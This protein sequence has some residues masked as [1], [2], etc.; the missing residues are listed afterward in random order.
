MRILGRVGGDEDRDGEAVHRVFSLR[1]DDPQ[2]NGDPGG[3]AEPG[4]NDP[5]AKGFRATFSGPIA[6]GVAASAPV[7]SEPWCESAAPRE[8]DDVT[9][10]L[11]AVTVAY[12]DALPDPCFVSDVRGH[13]VAW[14]AAA[15]RLLGWTSRQA[16]GHW[17][18]ALL[19]GV[20][21]GGAPVCAVH[22]DRPAR[23]SR[24][25][26]E[27]HGDMTVRLASGARCSVAVSALPVVFDGE[28]GLLH[29]LRPAGG[30]RDSLTGALTRPVMR[31]RAAD[32][33]AH[34]RRFGEPLAVAL[35]DVDHLKWIND[36]KSHA[37]GDAALIAIARSLQ[38]RRDDLV[39]RWGGDEFLALLPG[40]TRVHAAARLRRSVATLA[41]PGMPGT[42]SAGVTELAGDERL[43]DAL[44]RCDAALHAAKR[45]GRAAV[46]TRQA[47]PA[48]ARSGRQS[49]RPNG[50]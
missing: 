7:D 48:A 42:F 16:I 40:T 14:N 38:G 15:E 2:V 41:Q 45:A 23:A 22:C 8:G 18:G 6:T 47:W 33:Q 39:A 1:T 26:P 10:Q 9:V 28:P 13:V 21:A 3:S 24:M 4:S 20:D 19:A 11:P 50:G 32:E 5:G 25:D 29:V 35:V 49:A 30:D 27:P 31:L 12:V 17:C 43:D 46:H 37:A 36:E 44:A 34:A